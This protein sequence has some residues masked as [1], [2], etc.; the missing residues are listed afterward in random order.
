MKTVLLLGR[1]AL[2]AVLAVALV[3]LAFYAAGARV[4]QWLATDRLQAERSHRL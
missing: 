1:F 3:A 2:A 4:K